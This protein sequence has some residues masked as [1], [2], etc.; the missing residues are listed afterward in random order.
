[1]R[2][3]GRPLARPRSDGLR[4]LPT[5]RQRSRDVGGAGSFGRWP[6]ARLLQTIFSA[7]GELPDPRTQ[8]LTSSFL[9]PLAYRGL[10]ETGGHPMPSAAALPPT[11]PPP[12]AVEE[13]CQQTRTRLADGVDLAIVFFSTHH[14]REANGLVRMVQERLTPRCLLGCVAE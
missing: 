13:V 12:R 8:H 10:G 2:Y 3:A 6:F 1:R 9:W 5:A 11:E 14:A 7:S 4:R